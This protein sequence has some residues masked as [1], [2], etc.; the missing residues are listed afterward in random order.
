MNNVVTN[1]EILAYQLIGKN[2]GSTLVSFEDY[3]DA[4]DDIIMLAEKIKAER[5][6]VTMINTVNK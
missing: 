3:H 6:T 4:A 5:A 2:K 1:S